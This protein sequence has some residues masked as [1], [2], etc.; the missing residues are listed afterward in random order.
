MAQKADF[1]VTRGA[2]G[3]VVALTGD[4]ISAELG[5]APDRLM[6][7]CGGRADVRF[8]VSRLGRVDTAGAFA[9]L[10][11][12]RCELPSELFAHRPDTARL[13]DFIRDEART[14]RG[15]EPKR[16]PFYDLLVRAGQ[17]VVGFGTSFYDFLDFLGRL[18]MVIGGTLVRPRRLRTAPTVDLM[19]RAGVDALPV[20][21]VTSF[22]V[23]AVIAF[24]GAQLLSQFGASI[25][26]VELIGISVMREFGVVITGV[27]LAGRSASSFAAEIGAMKM[28][29]EVDAMQVLGIDPYEAL[30]LPRLI[31]MVVMTP[32]LTFAAVAAGL[33]GG[34]LVVWVV[35]QI[36][37]QVFMGRLETLTNPTGVQH[38]L[39]G[40]LKAPV[41]G[42]VVAIIGCQQGLEVGGDV[43]SLGRRVTS[44]VVQAI[45]AI[46]LIDAVFALVYMQLDV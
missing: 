38:L 33:I 14:E 8:D 35:L 46:I 17:G 3:A 25:F 44:A 15:P 31:A 39:L 9:L 4:W 5:R 28:N 32:I 36:S 27:L 18:M 40:L 29:Q 6:Q 1:T 11:S 37:P 2:N 19:E 7:Q 12:T 10:R 43:E 26:T 30:V 23:G 24:L 45:F 42:A 16:H 13:I 34:G 20:V 41:I 21:M 22:F